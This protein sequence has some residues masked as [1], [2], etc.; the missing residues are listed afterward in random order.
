MVRKW[1]ALG[2]CLVAVAGLVLMTV[3]IC[4]TKYTVK[5]RH[6]EVDYDLSTGEYFS[7]STGEKLDGPDKLVNWSSATANQDFSNARNEWKEVPKAAEGMHSTPIWVGALMFL[8]FGV[9]AFSTWKS[10]KYY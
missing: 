7:T 1:V 6:Y 10:I 3:G 2:L 9:A 5:T 8:I 4:T